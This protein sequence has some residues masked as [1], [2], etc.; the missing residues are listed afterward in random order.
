MNIKLC[1][2]DIS[3][4]A[5]VVHFNMRINAAQSGAK[6]DNKKSEKQFVRGG[7]KV[8]MACPPGHDLVNTPEHLRPGFRG[9]PRQYDPSEF[10]L[11]GR[12]EWQHPRMFRDMTYDTNAAAMET[13]RQANQPRRQAYDLPAAPNLSNLPEECLADVSMPSDHFT[14]ECEADASPQQ[15]QLC[16][17]SSPAGSTESKNYVDTIYDEIVSRFNS[18]RER[19]ARGDQMMQSMGNETDK[20]GN[21]STSRGPLSSGVQTNRRKVITTHCDPC[22]SVT[23]QIEETSTVLNDQRHLDDVQPPSFFNATD[24][25]A[26]PLDCTPMTSGAPYASPAGRRI[27]FSLM[28]QSE[29]LDQITMPSFRDDTLPPTMSTRIGQHR[30]A[31]D[32][33]LTD[34]SAPSFAYSDSPQSGNA[35]FQDISDITPPYLIETNECLTDMTLPTFSNRP[36]MSSMQC[37]YQI[38]DVTAP[39]FNRTMSREAGYSRRQQNI[40]EMSAPSFAS[41][42]RGVTA[43]RECLQDMSMPSF[44][45]VSG[46]YRSPRK[47]EAFS[48]PSSF[49]RG[50]AYNDCLED[51]SMPSFGDISGVSRGRNYQEFMPSQNIGEISAP[52]FG[53]SGRQPVSTDCLE[54][55]TTP[56]FGGIS[57]ASRG[58]SSQRRQ[59]SM[60]SQNI[61]DVSAPSFGD[62]GRGPV[63]NDCLEDMT[64]PS[65]GGVSGAS[66][67]RSSQRRQV[68]MPSQNICDVSAPSF[69]DSGRGPVSNECL[70]DMSVPSFGGVSGASRGRSLQRRQVSM[71]SQNICDVSAP[72]FG[73]SGRGP[74]SN[75]CLEDMTMPSFGGVSGA[76]RGRSS[77][78]RQ[79]SMPS[80]NICDVS[81]PS[82]GDSGRGPVSN[83]CLEDMSVPSFGGVSGASRGRSLQRRQVSMPSQNIFSND[84]LEDMTM[85]SFGGV[86]GASRGRSSQRRQ[87]SMPSQNICDVS[88]PSFG[89]SGRGPVS[90]ECLED[91]SVPS[92]GGVSGASRGRSLQRRQVSMPSQNICDVSAPSFGDSG[93]GPVSNDCLE[94]MTMPSFGG[95]SG[96]SRGR[97]S[98]RR[99][100]S[101]PS[102]NICDVSAPSFGDSGRGPVSNDCLEDMT[103]PSF[104]GVSG[105]SRGRSSQ[106]RQVS[107]P[108]QNIFSNDCLEDM[109]MPSFGGVSGASRGRSSQR[110]QVSMPSQNICD[111]S[112]PS[113]GDSGRGPVSNDCLED[114]TMP[115][116]GGVSGASRGRSS[117][118]RQVSM[119]SQ[120]I[121]DI[122]APSFGSSGRRPTATNCIEDRSPSFRQS[123]ARTRQMTSQNIQDISA[124]CFPDSGHRTIPTECLEDMSM[125]SLGVSQGVSRRQDTLPS[126]CLEDISAP[127]FERSMSRDPSR[128]TT[129]AYTSRERTTAAPSFGGVSASTMRRTQQRQQMEM[130]SRNIGEISAPSFNSSG[131]SGPVANECLEDQTMPSFGGISGASRPRYSPR[132]QA[133]M[134]TQN[135]RDISA[136]SFGNQNRRHVTASE[137]LDDMTMPSFVESSNNSRRQVTLPSECLNEVSAPTFARSMSRAASSRRGRGVLPCST[138]EQ[139][140]DMSMP[141]FRDISSVNS[142]RRPN[143]EPSFAPESDCECVDDVTPL[144]FGQ[145]ASRDRQQSM[146]STNI[147]DISA[148]FFGDSGRN[149]MTNEC[150][151]DMPTPSSRAR[152][153]RR[154]ANISNRPGSF[155]RPQEN[156][157][158]EDMSMPS[159]GGISGAS[160]ARSPRQGQQ[161]QSMPS[162]NIGDITA[163]SFGSS[164]PGPMVDECLNDMTM[165]SFGNVSGAPRKQVTL[166]SERLDQV[167][168]PSFARSIPQ[169]GTSQLRRRPRSFASST[170]TA[171][172]P[173]PSECIEDMPVPSFAGVSG[174]GQSRRQGR[175]QQ[176]MPSQN[177]CDESAPSYF[178]SRRGPATNE[179]LED[180][181]MPSFG[182]VSGAS[183]GRGQGRWQRSMPLQN[184]CDESAPSYFSSRRGPATNECLEDMTAPSFGGVSGAGFGQRNKSRSRGLVNPCVQRQQRSASV[185]TPILASTR[186]ADECLENVTMPSF[187]G[188][189][190]L[191]NEHQTVNG[192]SYDVNRLRRQRSMP[193]NLPSECLDDVS[194]PNMEMSIGSRRPKIPKK[195]A[196]TNERL[197]DVTMSSLRRNHSFPCLSVSQQQQQISDISAPSMVTSSVPAQSQA[198]HTFPSEQIENIS[199]PFDPPEGSN[200][201]ECGSAKELYDNQ[202]RTDNT[203][204]SRLEDVTMPSYEDISYS[205]RRHQLTMPG[206]DL[207][208]ITEPA[209]G[210]SRSSLRRI[211]SVMPNE[212]LEDISQPDFYTSSSR[213]D[214]RMTSRPEN[215]EDITMPSLAADVT[216]KSSASIH[217]VSSE[218]KVTRRM[219]KQSP[220]D[221]LADESA[222]SMLNDSGTVGQSVSP[223]VDEVQE[224]TVKTSSSVTRIYIKPTDS[225]GQQNI[226][227]PSLPGRNGGP[228]V[229]Y[230][231]Q[232]P[233]QQLI[234]ITYDVDNSPTNNLPSYHHS[235][236]GLQSAH[237]KGNVFITDVTEPSYAPSYDPTL[238]NVYDNMQGNGEATNNTYHGFDSMQNYVPFDELIRSPRTGRNSP[239]QG[240]DESLQTPQP[241][242]SAN[243]DTARRSPGSP[244]QMVNTSYPYG[245]PRCITR[246]PC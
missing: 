216:A 242:R 19:I 16:D 202:T 184:I 159:F 201:C 63:S 61:C 167:T 8:E 229:G 137:C 98:Q 77:Q 84:C 110:R 83:E 224:V 195:E 186:I 198:A 191:F 139:L 144:S 88:A 168:A 228:G 194:A 226:P 205:P 132:E 86:S 72:S 18:L 210:R 123:R 15:Q 146:P 53:S 178:S 75:D 102:Q 245:Q 180:M 126:Q 66:R 182:G 163:P 51:M 235:Q 200:N 187:G 108:S 138:N 234:T 46:A 192:G 64:M 111:V 129:F 166:P 172:D 22:G 204:S 94:D 193:D 93:R 196:V 89:D 11:T 148:P 140:D 220:S 157:C 230:L 169:R 177:I 161:G 12:E 109:T 41:S 208:D 203:N 25:G 142:G 222:P 58:R 52:T 17:T 124:P 131:R 48:T 175:A 29:N 151:D 81:A 60:P 85:P 45:G 207:N 31:T 20:C 114:M 221:Q 165:P 33:C 119:P 206:E 116:F 100:V 57:G 170:R 54:D 70:E 55:M 239:V 122:S 71:P 87:V 78:R 23:S 118:R 5:V 67:G 107:M 134:P 197:E 21:K 189:T 82:F 244:C 97:S 162:Q 158:L 181:T 92:F 36:Q 99:Q 176:P 155:R 121:Y 34:V 14:A 133:S 136:P 219:V 79:V 125:P 215:L 237:S 214:N 211:D 56:S 199:A 153:P 10:G 30:F 37:E 68:S 1:S 9:Q 232:G 35:A 160:R 227:I 90:N 209:K 91:M 76:S 6:S 238:E 49:G 174:A 213:T 43:D 47:S 26:Q 7:S 39:S 223:A 42:A 179:C 145:S 212:Q 13:F 246:R 233:D 4:H 156:E 183:Q 28:D 106:R 243:R 44:A 105:A 240:N 152:S 185:P 62:S 117:Q 141:T 143:S 80:Q 32:E 130:P 3:L 135:I 149:P 69:G 74:V 40:S 236:D 50:Q 150:L 127:T 164:S 217:H 218:Q 38:D 188:V 225:N 120:N 59:V 27:N 241:V 65:F 231:V 2:A 101:M 104:G 154:Q 173:M 112:A 95:V 113:F 171:R 190:S 115:S 128:R 24:M 147:R 96:A 73:D 103:M